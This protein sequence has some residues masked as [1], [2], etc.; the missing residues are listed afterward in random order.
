MVVLPLHLQRLVE[1]VVGYCLP[2]AV[3]VKRG[4][5][6]VFHDNVPAVVGLKAVYELDDVL[7][8]Q[9]AEDIDL[10]LVVVCYSVLLE[11]LDD[12]VLP[13]HFRFREQNPA[14]LPYN[15]MTWS[16][17][18]V[19]LGLDNFTSVLICETSFPL[20]PYHFS[21]LWPTSSRCRK[22]FPRQ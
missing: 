2:F 17:V 19:R 7:V 5:V 18:V 13:I 14:V 1:D 8:V 20:I 22:V 21:N 4:L 11:L 9:V 10:L 12:N 15:H 16:L 6:G 3:L